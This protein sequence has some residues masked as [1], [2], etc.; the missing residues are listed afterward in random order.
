MPDK[1]LKTPEVF[2]CDVG[3]IDLEDRSY[4]TATAVFGTY[5]CPRCSNTHFEI[6]IGGVM[7]LSMQFEPL[8]AE[9]IANAFLNPRAAPEEEMRKTPP[10]RRTN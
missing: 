4:E 1:K 6:A 8:Q 3:V 9:E 10:R 5:I 2:V 7:K